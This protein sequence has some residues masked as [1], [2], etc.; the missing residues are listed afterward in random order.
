MQGCQGMMLGV[1]Q[2]KSERVFWSN[3]FQE[4]L[5]EKNCS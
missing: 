3:F 5:E 2:I 4:Y 1:P